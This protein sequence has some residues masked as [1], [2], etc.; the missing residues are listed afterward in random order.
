MK[1]IE[2]GK[3]KYMSPSVEIWE[4]E[5]V[6]MDVSMPDTGEGLGGT[7]NVGEDPFAETEDWSNE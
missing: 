1:C 6:S 7:V 5:K 3:E 4:F 2:T